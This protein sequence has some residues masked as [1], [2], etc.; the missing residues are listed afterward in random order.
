[1]SVYRFWIFQN[2]MLLRETASALMNS[3][4]LRSVCRCADSFAVCLCYPLPGL[5]LHVRLPLQQ[6]GAV[7][8][9]VRHLLQCLDF[10]SH[11][12]YGCERRHAARNTPASPS[13]CQPSQRQESTHDSSGHNYK[14]KRV[15][16][17]LLFKNDRG[18]LQG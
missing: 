1:M 2:C 5:P 10:P 6:L 3:G 9:L 13:R 16:I 15:S 12:V 11:R 17:A 8:R 18:R 14:I 7:L 4:S